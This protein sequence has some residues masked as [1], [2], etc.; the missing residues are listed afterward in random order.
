VGGP[1]SLSGRGDDEKNSQLLPGFEFPIIQTVAQRSTTEL[2]WLKA[3]LYEKNHSRY[4]F[5]VFVVVL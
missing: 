3:Y 1:Q 5:Q 4:L 2:S